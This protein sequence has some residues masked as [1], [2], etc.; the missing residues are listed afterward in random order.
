MPCDHKWEPGRLGHQYRPLGTW[1]MSGHQVCWKCG[2]E[3]WVRVREPDEPPYLGAI[4]VYGK[5]VYPELRGISRGLAGFD[6]KGEVAIVV[7]GVHPHVCFI[8]ALRRELYAL[9]GDRPK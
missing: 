5:P 2:A 9:L 6:G 4:D 3:R 8:E 1:T 7:G